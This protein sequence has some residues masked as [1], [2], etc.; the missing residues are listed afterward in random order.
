MGKFPTKLEWV[1]S[2]HKAIVQ[3]DWFAFLNHIQLRR[4]SEECQFKQMDSVIFA[5]ARRA[6][7]GSAGG[8]R[9]VGREIRPEF[10]GTDFLRCCKS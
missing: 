9:I 1:F 3:F 8:R 6:V 7:K 2:L 5:D 10:R 4:N